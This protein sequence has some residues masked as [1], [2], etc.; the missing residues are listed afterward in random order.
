VSDFARSIAWYQTIL[1]FAADAPTPAEPNVSVLLARDDARLMLRG[2]KVAVVR[3]LTGQDW[4]VYLRLDGGSLV[5]LLDHARKQTPLV[6][7]P[8]LMANGM[9]EFELEDPDGHRIC[10]A[11]RLADTTG[12]PRAVD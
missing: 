2:G 12:F 1:G 4:D 7:G 11:E 8:E 5:E 9:V 10:V 3:P 6:R